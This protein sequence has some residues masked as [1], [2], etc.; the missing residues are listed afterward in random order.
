M[1]EFTG[2]VNGKALHDRLRNVPEPETCG[3]TYNALLKEEGSHAG[4]DDPSPMAER[5]QESRI[6]ALLDKVRRCEESAQLPVQI[7]FQMSAVNSKD[8]HLSAASIGGRDASTFLILS[9][10]F[11]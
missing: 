1:V 3:D 11:S 2:T 9:L 4:S 5:Y 7:Q 6:A 10:V 8:F